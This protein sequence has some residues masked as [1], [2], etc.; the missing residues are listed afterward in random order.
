MYHNLTE[1]IDAIRETNDALFELACAG[2]R[3]DGGHHKQWYLELIIDL[4]GWDIDAV[5]GDEW[6]PGIA[7]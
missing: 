5:R 3:T 7:P 1:E 4:L 6:E 2:C